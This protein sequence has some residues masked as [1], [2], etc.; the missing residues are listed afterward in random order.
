MDTTV[1]LVRARDDQR[2]VL[3][4]LIQFYI[5]DFADFMRPGQELAFTEDGQFA[6]FPGIEANWG[7]PDREVWFIRVDGDLAGFALINKHGHSGR[8]VDFNVA[9]F[10]VARQARRK[11]AGAIAIQHLL[12]THPGVWEIAIAERNKPAQSFWPRA[13]AS[14]NI[15]DLQTLQ[16]DGV[17]WTGP[18]LRFKAR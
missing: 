12:K 8:P 11:G 1:E 14:A 5:H 16:G 7:A 3:N 6:P 13:I 10:F 9:E 17:E 2:H 4:N 15:A 18:I